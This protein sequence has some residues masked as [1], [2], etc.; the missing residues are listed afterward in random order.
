MSD[1]PIPISTGPPAGFTAPT[2]QNT[3]L[4]PAPVAGLS[5]P[6]IPDIA[7]GEEE[8]KEDDSDDDD[9]TAALAG[10][11][12]AQAAIYSMVQNKLEGLVGKSSGYI[13][14]LPLPVRKRIEG[15]KGVHSEFTKIEKEYKREMVELDRKYLGLY[16]PVFERRRAILNG[17]AEPTADEL[18]AGH[19]LTLKDDP[20]AEPLPEKEEGDAE[21]KDTKGIPEFWLT[22]LRNHMDISEMITERD[23]EAI[24]SL[25]DVTLDLLP[26]TEGFRLTFHFSPNDFFTNETLT[27]TYYYE[28]ELDYLGDWNYKRAEG[29]TINWKEDKDLTKTIEVRKQRNKNTNRTRIVRKSKKTPSFFDFFSPPVPPSESDM[30]NGEIDDDELDELRYKLEQDYDVGEDLKERVIPRAIDYF[31]GKALEYDMLDD[32][33]EIE[34]DDDDEDH[35]HDDDEEES[36][37]DDVPKKK[38]AGK[39][40]AAGGGGQ[41]CKNQ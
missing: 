24:K 29:C 19:E 33:E 25:T 27:K 34:G 18:K 39:A 17:E 4:N 21:A 8:D 16:K 22:A 30:K 20:E 28:P 40:A 9:G 23:E 15:L 7:E 41:D 1:K 11:T 12:G 36:S 31:T 5:K 10:M 38:K 37:E 35:D 3:P 6:T 2:P 26:N 32:E 14:S 13:E